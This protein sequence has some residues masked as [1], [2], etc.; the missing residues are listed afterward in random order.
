VRTPADL[1]RLGLAAL[2]NLERM[3]QKSADNILQAIEKSKQTTLARFI[4]AL[5][6]R[7]VGETTAKD[8]AK[9]LGNLDRL[10]AI[11]EI[12]LQQIPDIGP[13][14]A[15]SIINFFAESHNREV[16]E[17]LRASGV[18]WAEHEG[19][20]LHADSILPLS[21]KTFVLTGT[22]ATMSREQAKEKIET[23]G[24]KV[25]NSVSKK[26]DY[27]IV[28]SDPGSKHDKAMSL[29]VT[30]LNEDELMILLNKVQSLS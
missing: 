9:Y 16:I 19:K 1:Y 6:I 25:S 29:G 7:N 15:Q 18:H 14:V 28:G 26:T 4:Y 10:I 13:V 17:Q 21:G 8:L 22:L 27:V 30:I 3:A 11:D 24:A 20:L 2:V 23:L 12:H 5:G